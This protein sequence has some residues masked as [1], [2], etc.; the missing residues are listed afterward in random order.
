MSDEGQR[1]TIF[2]AVGP[3]CVVMELID[4]TQMAQHVSDRARKGCKEPAG[5]LSVRALTSGRSLGG[6]SRGRPEP[7]VECPGAP[8]AG[9]WD[10]AGRSAPSTPRRLCGRTLGAGGR[11]ERSERRAPR[12]AP[13]PVLSAAQAAQPL[14]V[15]SARDAGLDGSRGWGGGDIACLVYGPSA[16][17][18]HPEASLDAATSGCLLCLTLWS[19]RRGGETDGRLAPG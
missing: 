13:V 6:S 16:V 7:R 14:A 10:G 12:R 3:G 4:F 1:N 19:W 8:P 9:A 18:R 17:W 2:W 5:R 15:S 11:T